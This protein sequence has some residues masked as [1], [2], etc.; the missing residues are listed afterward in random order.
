MRIWFVYNSTFRIEP[1]DV[2]TNTT[3]PARF[4]FVFVPE[5]F[6]PGSPPTVV[7]CTVCEYTQQ[8]TFSGVY[9]TNNRNSKRGTEIKWH[10]K[11]RRKSNKTNK[12]TN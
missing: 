7:Q 6:E 2:I 8:C 11:M 1:Q 3:R 5:Q 10:G 9:I 12:E 4:S